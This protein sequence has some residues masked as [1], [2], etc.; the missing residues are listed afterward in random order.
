MT[1]R[2]PSQIAAELA[3]LVRGD[4]FADIIHRVAYSTDSSSYR[5]VPQ[6]VVAPQDVR[7]V[8]AVVQYARD[9]GLPVA[10]RGAGSG[11]AGESL[12]SGIVLDMTRYMKANHRD[13]RRARHVRAG[14]GARRSEQ[15]AGADRAAR[16]DRI[17]PAPTGL[18]SGAS[19]GTTPPALIPSSTATP[20]PTSRP[21]RR[22]CRTAT[23][24]EFRNGVDVGQVQGGGQSIAKDCW[25][26]LTA[27]QAIDRQGS[28]SDQT[29]PNRLSHRGRL[30]R[31]SD[32]SGAPPR[33]FGGDAGD[34]HERHSQ[35]GA[36]ACGQGTAPTG[37][38]FVRQHGAGRA[39]DRG[40]QPGGLRADG[41]IAGRIWRSTSF[42]STGTSCRPALRRCC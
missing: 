7:D 8:V 6:C 11:V 23:V 15:A 32:R 38:R 28:A 30:P 3:K 5:I 13:R 39:H 35:D 18:R 9:L 27:N 1:Q 14:R 42:L 22:C 37:V 21:S 2:E 29:Q 17:L 31:Q 4:V 25:S 19:W 41:S 33:G 20:R 24:V 34:L 16:S 26:L 10:P 40:H 12:C 36:A